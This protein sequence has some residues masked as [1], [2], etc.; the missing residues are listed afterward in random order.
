MSLLVNRWY[1]PGVGRWI[2]EDPIGF[3]GGDANL[4]R[5][6]ENSPTQR[7]DP[8]GL[9]TLGEEFFWTYFARAFAGVFVVPQL[10]TRKN[11]WSED[12]FILFHDDGTLAKETSLQ[13][14]DFLAKFALDRLPADGKWH[15]L[16]FNWTNIVEYLGLGVI[17][18]PG[19]GM[20]SAGWWLSGGS[21]FEGDGNYQARVCRLPDR[22]RVDFRNET[23]SWLWYDKIDGNS[24]A[25]ALEKGSFVTEPIKAFLETTLVDIVADKILG[26][27]YF[28]VVEL[29]ITNPKLRTKW[30]FPK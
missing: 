7:T 28:A 14:Y 11:N 26:A 13:R 20:R 2:S 17:L 8:T 6:A 16:A 21:R 18:I 25:E 10:V 22:I 9:L 12:G 29:K 4:M 24:F 5:Y 30:F 23:S 19:E 15:N 27:S 3:A 1:D